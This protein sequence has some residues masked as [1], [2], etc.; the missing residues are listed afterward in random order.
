[1]FESTG[2]CLVIIFHRDSWVT[3]A[4]IITLAVG[5]ISADSEAAEKK[6]AA[7]NPHGNAML[8][9]ACHTSVT[10]GAL[11]FEGN[12]TQLCGSCH[13]GRLAGREVH[14]VNVAPTAAIAGRIPPEFPLKNGLITC[15]TCHDMRPDCGG[16]PPDAK[17]TYH[18]LRG[19]QTSDPLAFCSHCHASQDYRPFNAHDQ[20][21]ARHAK[22]DTCAWC[23]VDVP[24]VNSYREEAAPRTLRDTSSRVCANC[25]PMM[26]GHPTHAHVGATPSQEFLWHMSAYEMQ[27]K[28]RMPFEQLLK[29]ASASRRTPRAI[30]L[31]ENGRIAC[32]T[33][34]NPHEKGLLSEANPGSL[35][36]EPKQA[37]HHRLRA[38]EGKVCIVCH[39]K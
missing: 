28:L 38:R 14:P 11:R 12:V 13:D 6:V 10:G 2:K 29:Y 31:D 24:D 32:Y 17:S 33:C 3:V 34:H 7:E 8:C 30:P 1:L 20:L 25:H 36:A 15:F 5:S 21:D 18:L 16:R 9:T 27:P 26:E 22:T 19:W 37:A 4:L 39:E 23:H 35:G